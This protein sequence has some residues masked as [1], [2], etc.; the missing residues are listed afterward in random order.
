[1]HIIV[2]IQPHRR[3]CSITEHSSHQCLTE[4]WI[5]IK[6][7]KAVSRC[8]MQSEQAMHGRCTGVRSRV[9]GCVF[10]FNCFTRLRRWIDLNH[11]VPGRRMRQGEVRGSPEGSVRETLLREHKEDQE[12]NQA[13]SCCSAFKR[14]LYQLVQC[15]RACVCVPLQYFRESHSAQ[16][17]PCIPDTA[18][19]RLRSLQ[20]ALHTPFEPAKHEEHAQLLCSLWLAF[21]GDSLSI[22]ER[23]SSD[24][25]WKEIGFQSHEPATDVRSGG[26]LSVQCLVHMAHAHPGVFAFL[27]HKE[28]AGRSELEY[29][30][31]AAGVTLVHWLARAI[32]LSDEKLNSERSIEQTLTNA[33]CAFA[34]LLEH[35][36]D[37][38]H[39][40]FVATYERLDKEWL[41]GR[42][43]YMQFQQIVLPSAIEATVSALERKQ[44][45]SVC[46]F[47]AMLHLEQT[48]T[49]SHNNAVEAAAA[50]ATVAAAGSDTPTAP[51]DNGPCREHR[52]SHRHESA[53]S[54]AQ[55]LRAR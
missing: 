21:F 45:R 25:H 14:C 52:R 17:L 13:L 4:A 19:S 42:A 41:A 38:F 10:P 7:S 2:I 3:E 35:E 12:D 26:L 20:L 55:Q 49:N 29:P 40:I 27:A 48:H 47:R 32:G 50:A 37:A 5:P 6:R 33:G 28:G 36:P 15:M 43:T 8:S 46:G 9:F 30:F 53:Q 51:C 44:P 54:V 16:V 24:A 39:E 22:P 31:A 1:M 11:Q 23:V 18:L 34:Y